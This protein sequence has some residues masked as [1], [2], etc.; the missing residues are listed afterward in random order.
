MTTHTVRKTSASQNWESFLT[1]VS[2]F[3][4]LT[5]NVGY[6]EGVDDNAYQEAGVS[7]LSSAHKDEKCLA[8][9]PIS[10]AKGAIPLYLP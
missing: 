9:P 6:R 2:W 3:S 1:I 4:K 7:S 5:S 10:H 8:V